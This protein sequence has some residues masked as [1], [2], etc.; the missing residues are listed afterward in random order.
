MAYKN[1]F[2]Y[3]QPEYFTGKL[4]LKYIFLKQNVGETVWISVWNITLI[5]SHYEIMHR[6]KNAM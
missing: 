4:W 3:L 5:M 2:S 6:G 1:Y